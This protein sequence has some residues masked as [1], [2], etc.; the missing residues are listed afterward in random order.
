MRRFLSLR[1]HDAAVALVASAVTA[2]VVAPAIWTQVRVEQRR[3]EA[4]EQDLERLRET[5]RLRR[6]AELAVVAALLEQTEQ[7]LRDTAR[8]EAA[9][10]AWEDAVRF[11]TTAP[12][13]D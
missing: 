7:V 11:S 5:E 9:I 13:K 2:G 6:E 3:A 8:S 1:R 10:K 12:P 4:A